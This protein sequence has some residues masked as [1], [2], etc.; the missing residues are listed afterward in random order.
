[1][2]AEASLWAPW[3]PHFD[4]H[5]Q[6]HPQSHLLVLQSEKK[7]LFGVC[8]RLMAAIS[9]TAQLLWKTAIRV[10][11]HGMLKSILALPATH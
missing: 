8:C 9:Y 11:R 5:L 2:R 6:L 1:M 7:P 4:A 3:S 10:E